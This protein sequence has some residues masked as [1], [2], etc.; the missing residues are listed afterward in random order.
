[1]A[2]FKD[3]FNAL[4]ID[5]LATE[6]S[7]SWAE[8]PT[9]RWRVLASAR[10]D[11]LRLSERIELFAD[12]LVTCLPDD[13][14]EAAQII[15]RALC[16]PAFT[17]WMTM[18]VGTYVAKTGI[19]QPERALAV[20]AALTPRFSSEGP[21]RVFIGNVLRADV[22]VPA[23]VGPRPDE[24]V[25]RL[26]SEGTR[27]RLPWARQLRAFIIDP[28]PTIALLDLLYDDQSP[29]V[30]RSVAN[31]L[32]DISKDHP[33][34]VV[35]V[36]RRWLSASP[37][38]VDVVRHG[39]RTLIKRGEPTALEILGFAHDSTVRLVDLVCKPAALEIGDVATFRFTL[40]ADVETRAAI[41]YV[42]HYQGASGLKAGKVFKLTTRTLAAGHLTAFERRHRFGHVSIRRIHPGPHRIDV[43]VNGRVLGGV[44]LTIEGPLCS[45]G[46]PFDQG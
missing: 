45:G 37:Q 30:R 5:S 21:I 28:T 3:E 4:T 40:E 36:A 12:A 33:E 14:G 17:G 16:S 29:Y 19:D 27:P 38:R 18:P 9:S 8:F 42:V 44:D 20:L 46:E 13:F 39:L 34:L 41:D 25:R 22:S 10:L 7:R 24:H 31:H 2:D 23:R 26:V 15:E 11:E 35:N 1:M 6:L 43:Q 32:N